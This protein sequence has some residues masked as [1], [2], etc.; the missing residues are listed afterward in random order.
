MPAWR[1]RVIDLSRVFAE[2]VF[3]LRPGGVLELEDGLGVEQVRLALA[4]P[5]VLAADLEGAVGELGR[6][7]GVGAGMAGRHLGRNHVEP[8][9]FEA[10][11]RTREIPVDD[12]AGQPDRLEDLG[13]R[14]RTR[15]C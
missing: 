5:L 1:D 6:V 7:V 12:G 15:R 8:D 3:A 10:A 9:A 11:R 4:A 14:C 2:H 13:L